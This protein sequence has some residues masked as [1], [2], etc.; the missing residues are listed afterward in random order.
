MKKLILTLF[1]V[2]M[3]F[4][5]LAADKEKESAFD[6]VMRTKTLRCGY[7]IY[8]PFFSKDPNTGEFSGLFHDFTEQIGKELGIKIE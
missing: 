6:R 3:P 5:A 7:T 2:L 4:L 8:P 1:L